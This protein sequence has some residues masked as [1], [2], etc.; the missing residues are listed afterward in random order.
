MSAAQLTTYLGGGKYALSL[1]GVR[2]FLRDDAAGR[3]GH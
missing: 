1:E 3:P 2:S